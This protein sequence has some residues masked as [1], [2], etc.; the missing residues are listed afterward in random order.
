MSDWQPIETAPYS[1][2]VLA[3]LHL[4]KNP[5]ASGPVIGLWVSLKSIE[6]DSGSNP[7]GSVP[8]LRHDS[9]KATPP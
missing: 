3:W 6:F 1:T 9:E 2:S 7:F 8:Y 5:D 4:P